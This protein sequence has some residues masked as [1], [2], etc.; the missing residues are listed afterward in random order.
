TT[1][2][3]ALAGYPDVAEKTRQRVLQAAEEMGYY[4]N[5]TARRL[6]RCRADTIGFIIPT[7]GPRFSD[8]FFSEF[9]AGIGNEASRQR[10][11]LLVAT[12][13]PGPTELET[14]RRWAGS[15]R[16]DG[17]LLVR[18]RRDDPRIR[19]L[20]GRGIPFVSY[21]RSQVEVDF[22]YVGVDGER[23]MYE[24]AQYLIGLGH[25]EIAYI[26][27]PAELQFSTDRLAGVR[28]ALEEHGLALRPEHHVE[29]QLTEESGYRCARQLLATSPHPTAIMCANDLMALG[30]MRAVQEQGLRVGRDVAVTGFDD[31]PLAAHA[32][33]PLT[34]VRQPIYQIGTLTCRMLVRLIC[35]EELEERHIVLTPELVVRRSTER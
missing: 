22:P 2:S 9:L 26:G 10:M 24:A 17:F 31:I 14:Y 28:R 15:R 20:A 3:R 30:A 21:G 34:T 27:G 13:P 33:P 29:G 5:A 6:Q 16:V 18:T 4:P 12:H 8:P 1:V 11:D 19:F 23:G 25:Q 35:G 32:F 7:S